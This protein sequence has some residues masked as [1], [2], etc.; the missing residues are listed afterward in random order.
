[1]TSTL[2][3][4]TD[5]DLIEAQ[6][7]WGLLSSRTLHGKAPMPGFIATEPSHGFHKVFGLVIAFH[8]CKDRLSVGVTLGPVPNP[9]NGTDHQIHHGR[10][11]PHS[12]APTGGQIRDRHDQQQR[13]RTLSMPS[14]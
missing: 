11:C 2:A 1:M 5:H 12:A 4:K 14:V 7:L 6:C 3:S 13:C 10:A 9:V 8:L